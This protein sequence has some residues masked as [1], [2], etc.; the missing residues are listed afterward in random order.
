MKKDNKT[1]EQKIR[2][3]LLKENTEKLKNDIE[4]YLENDYIYKN[5]HRIRGDIPIN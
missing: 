3:V 5:R 4:L 2:S 1:L